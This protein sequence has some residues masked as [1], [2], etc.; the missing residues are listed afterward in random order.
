M[1]YLHNGS[2]AIGPFGDEGDARAFR[3]ETRIS[4]KP[5]PASQWLIVDESE[6]ELQEPRRARVYVDILSLELYEPT[7]YQ[8]L[9]GVAH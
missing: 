2:M 3:R 7:E 6:V 1:K 8:E 4:G 5:M 9:I